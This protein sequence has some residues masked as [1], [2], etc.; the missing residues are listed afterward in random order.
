M[1]AT[2]TVPTAIDTLLTKAKD[3]TAVFGIVGLGY[4]GLPFAMEIVR[5]G[6]RV[7]GFDVNPRVVDSLNGGRSHIQD[8]PAGTVADAVKAKRFAATADL[9]RLNEPDVISI[10]VPTPLSKTKDPDVSYVLAATESVRRALRKGQLV[11]LESTT[12]PGT[13]RE[14]MLPALESTGL[15]VGED[16]FLAFSPER[17]DPG[18][19]RFNTR[20]T[21][22]VVGGITP[23]CLRSRWHCISRPSTRSCRSPPRRRQSSSRSSRTLSAA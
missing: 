9:A 20:N 19:E 10:S 8:V 18:N 12:Y 23:A 4:G 1:T 15:K 6:Y 21:P 16:F 5:A 14:L 2:A 7:L 3:R 17:V 13:T 11:V 22:K